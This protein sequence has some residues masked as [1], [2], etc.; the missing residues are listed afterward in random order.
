MDPASKR[1]LPW[2]PLALGITALLLLL[3]IE[4]SVRHEADPSLEY[5]HILRPRGEVDSFTGL[6]SKGLELA[7]PNSLE[8]GKLLSRYGWALG[9]EVGD[10]QKSKEA[11][12]EALAIAMDQEDLDGCAWHLQIG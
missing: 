5:I 8:A 1:D 6:I 2:V 4:R 11:L 10:Y 7:P 12:D 9:Q 3:L